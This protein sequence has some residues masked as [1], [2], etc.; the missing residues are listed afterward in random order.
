[1]YESKY[2][3]SR[4]RE[5][6]KE[7]SITQKSMLAEAGLG[8]NTMSHLDNGKSI[9]ADSLAR[10]ADVL[11]C[12]VDYLLGRVDYKDDA[13]PSTDLSEDEQEL[14][15]YFRSLDRTGRRHVLSFAEDERNAL[16]EKGTGT[17]SA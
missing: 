2:V 10:I 9:A 7:R 16:V 6:S 4:I 13:Q 1:M 5:R 17:T 11:A 8:G 14:L 12:S 3:A 15:E